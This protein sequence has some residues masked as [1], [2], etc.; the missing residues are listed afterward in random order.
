MK[1]KQQPAKKK[2]SRVAKWMGHPKRKYPLIGFTLLVL[3]LGFQGAAYALLLT[4]AAV[5]L[6]LLATVA[7]TRYRRRDRPLYVPH[8]LDKGPARKE[9]PAPPAVTQ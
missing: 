1:A 6:G 7:L 5:V 3:L 9:P 2:Q 8:G 4:G